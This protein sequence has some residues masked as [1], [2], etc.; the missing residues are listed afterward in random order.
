MF[1]CEPF[2][3]F[4]VNVFDDCRCRLWKSNSIWKSQTKD[5][6]HSG[7]RNQK[8]K[9]RV[10]CVF[11]FFFHV[12]YTCVFKVKLRLKIL[13]V[14]DPGQ[15]GKSSQ[16]SGDKDSRVVSVS[17]T[18]LFFF[19]LRLHGVSFSLKLPLILSGVR[20]LHPQEEVEH[21]YF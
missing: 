12:K 11:F 20:E 9:V 13:I 2:P 14:V 8:A 10:L 7:Y 4:I 17:Y 15:S 18:S 19:K 3:D 5:R 1:S 16:A 21:H 6:K